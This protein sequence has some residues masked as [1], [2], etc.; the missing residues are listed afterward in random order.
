M[1]RLSDKKG[2]T[3]IEI[4]VA[5]VIIG[6]V[7]AIAVPSIVGYIDHMNQQ[8]VDRMAA[9][10]AKSAQTAISHE[11]SSKAD[12]LPGNNGVQFIRDSQQEGSSNIYYYNNDT[13]G[14]NVELQNLIDRYIA[15][16]TIFN[17]RIIIKYDAEAGKVTYVSYTE[18]DKTGE[19]HR[20]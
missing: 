9:S 14:A 11:Y 17:N 19:W 4:V 3:L 20:Q 6:I 7:A 13:P 1:K 8:R 16:K 5:M 15:D 2:M 12:L 18:G 10:I